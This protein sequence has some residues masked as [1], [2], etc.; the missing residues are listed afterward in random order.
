[1]HHVSVILRP[2][3]RHQPRSLKSVERA[4]FSESPLSS[5]SGQVKGKKKKLAAACKQTAE[6]IESIKHGCRGTERWNGFD[7]VWRRNVLLVQPLFF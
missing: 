4:V 5:V 3:S 1:M 2:P 6:R 7:G